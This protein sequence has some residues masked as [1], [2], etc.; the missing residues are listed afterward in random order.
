LRSIALVLSLITCSFLVFG[1][2]SYSQASTTTG[3]NC[4]LN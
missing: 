3:A 1:T 2:V 4:V